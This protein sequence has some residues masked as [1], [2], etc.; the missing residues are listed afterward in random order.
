MSG[1]TKHAP[2][3]I[4]KMQKRHGGGGVQRAAA[5]N[6]LKGKHYQTPEERST[7]F[8]AANAE[9]H[10]AHEAQD[11]AW[12]EMKQLGRAGTVAHQAGG[13]AFGPPRKRQKTQCILQ[14]FNGTSNS[15][16]VSAAEAGIADRESEPSAAEAGNGEPPDLAAA[17]IVPLAPQPSGITSSV[18]VALRHNQL[19]NAETNW[20]CGQREPGN[21]KIRMHKAPGSV[22]HSCNNGRKHIAKAFPPH[23]ATRASA[24]LAEPCAHQHCRICNHCL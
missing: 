23:I 10:R 2:K 5:S 14:C 9:F 3:H 1:L 4:K 24:A 16:P 17:A 12:A 21:G 15:H 18:A 19:Q 8:K 7:I 11:E 22:A 20:H 13:S 6:F